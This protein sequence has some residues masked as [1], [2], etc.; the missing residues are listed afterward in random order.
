MP[1]P[2]CVLAQEPEGI[3]AHVCGR[4]TGAHA[5]HAR[6]THADRRAQNRRSRCSRCIRL[7]IASSSAV[8][9]RL[10]SLSLRRCRSRLRSTRPSRSFAS[11]RFR[12]TWHVSH[13]SSARTLSAEFTASRKDALEPRDGRA[14]A[15]ET[16][17]GVHDASGRCG[18]PL[19]VARSRGT[20][21]R[22]TSR[23]VA[24]A[25]VARMNVVAVGEHS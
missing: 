1:A 19:H 9:D 16:A 4:V 21:P 2:P 7:S 10:C 3:W 12:Q 5:P 22:S 14:F 15:A 24:R 18:S 17:H 13:A 6:P 8:R 20:R 25:V 23:S 11:T